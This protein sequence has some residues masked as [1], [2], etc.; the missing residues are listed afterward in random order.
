MKRNVGKA[1]LTIVE[2][3]IGIGERMTIFATATGGRIKDSIVYWG[4]FPHQQKNPK[5]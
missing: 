3:P 2:T 4:F 5:K 1:V